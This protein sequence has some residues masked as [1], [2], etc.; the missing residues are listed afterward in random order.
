MVG[1]CEVIEYIFYVADTCISLGHLISTTTDMDTR[2]EP[3]IWLAFYVTSVFIYC[4]GG[5]FFWR[6]SNILAFVSIIILV[7]YCLG[8]A[9]FVDFGYTKY[10]N[11]EAH[12]ENGH[13]ETKFHNIETIDIDMVSGSHFNGGILMF[14]KAFPLAGW[15]F[16]GIESLNFASNDILEVT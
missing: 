4:I 11:Y 14:L 13:N 12:Y 2:F 16:I 9:A 7:I 5:A 3:L 1:I 6:V 10:V 8:S 15:F